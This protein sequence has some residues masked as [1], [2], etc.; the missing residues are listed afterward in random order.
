MR[1]L[2]LILVLLS[3]N[4]VYADTVIHA[5][6]LVDVAAGDVLFEQTIRNP[7]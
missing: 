3:I 5:G 2:C 4:S 6:Q 7:G 1:A